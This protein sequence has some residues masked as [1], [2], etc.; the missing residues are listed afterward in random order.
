MSDATLS[1]LSDLIDRAL[2]AG[3][4][5]ADAVAA[6]SASLSIACRM[7]ESEH[8]ERSEAQD[9]GLRVFIGQRAAIVS[10]SDRSPE[11]LGTLVDRAVAMARLVPE[12]KYA[13]LADAA[14]IAPGPYADLQ[15][16]D[17]EE[18]DA[19]ALIAAAR[20][21]EAAA[22]AVPGVTNS[23]GADASWGRSQAIIV[24]SN[25]FR[26]VIANSRRSLSVSV[27]A[28][29][30][31]GMETDYDHATAVFAGDLPSPEAIGRSAGER[32]V[33]RLKPR[34]IPT[35][36][37][38][39]IYDPR[40]AR[41]LLGHLAGAITGSAIARGTS[42]LK[43]SLG[44]QV[45]PA[46]INVIDDPLRLRGL[47]SRAVDG[48]GIA[49]SRRAIIDKGVLTTWLMDLRSARQLGLASTGHASRGVS[50]PPSPG[51]SNFYM[52][53]GTLS[54]EEMIAEVGT[55]F[56]VT[57][58]M[59]QGINMVT[60]DYS[61]GASGFWIEN[62]EIAYP[63]N[64][65]TIAGNLKDMFLNLTAASDLEF[66][67]GTDAPTLRIDGMTVSGG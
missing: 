7:G 1:L 23:E 55:G 30:G 6:E 59:G 18:P 19:E 39:V 9:L 54:P 33:R 41:G 56:Y 11:A 26:N 45:L 49:T 51:T 16:V 14:Q 46:G 57:G 28:G 31:T 22:L 65:A 63:V 48:E 25:G 10:S 29:E 42:F 66:R 27:I 4:D 8:V 35:G 61:R 47:R 13:G 67:F 44:Q 5:S 21:A 52:E 53:A 15:T 40:V 58:L 2:K 34:K 32:T 12:D 3:A 20:E 36:R 24:A 50:S 38:P 60:G 64:E 62:G 17:A 37:F 43:D